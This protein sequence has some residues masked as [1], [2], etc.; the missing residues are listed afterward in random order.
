VLLGQVLLDAG[1]IA[2]AEDHLRRGLATLESR[3]SLE[4]RRKAARDA[5]DRLERQ[6]AAG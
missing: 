1:Q 3:P 6:R 2:E 5:L 4:A